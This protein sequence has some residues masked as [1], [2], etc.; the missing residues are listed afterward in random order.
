MKKIVFTGGGSA[1][2]VIPN[3]ALID[4]LTFAQPYYIG[5]GGIE[6]TLVNVPFYE[7]ECPKLIRSLTPKNLTIPF[8]LFKAQ[9]EAETV[10]KKLSPNLV[11]SKGGYVAL[12]VVLAAKKL[13]IPVLAH[14]SDLSL[15][16][17]NK[18]TARFAKQV[19]TSFP[20]TATSLK[21]GKYVSSP[22]RETLFTGDRQSALK[23][24]G[25]SGEKKIVLVFGGGS[26]S[27]TIGNAVLHFLKDILPFADVLHIVGKGN[28]S[29]RKEQGYVELEYEDAMQDAYAVADAVVCRAGSNTLFELLA[30]KL[31]ALVIPLE[32]GSRGDQKENAE[33]FSKKHLVKV[34]YEKDLNNLPK[35]IKALLSDDTIKENLKKEPIRNGNEAVI[36][37][38]E[39]YL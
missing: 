14:E 3:L 23:K 37:I 29:G 22:I 1:G 11:F 34:L 26:G 6:K 30:L 21:N 36:K 5:S 24:Y 31:P 17:A 28:L 2:H 38:M 8:K 4:E 27:K 33:Y 15:G 20:E 10:L 18:I 25:F 35:E 39:Q 16:L 9:K 13:K 7:I 12:P 32:Q 19:L